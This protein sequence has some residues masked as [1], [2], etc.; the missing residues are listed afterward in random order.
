[1]VCLKTPFQCELKAERRIQYTKYSIAFT[2]FLNTWKNKILDFFYSI[3]NSIS[4]FHRF[5]G[6][7]LSS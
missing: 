4:I 7:M 5:H 6:G 1:M 3:L 2:P